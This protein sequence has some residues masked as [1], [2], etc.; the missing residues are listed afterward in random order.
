[1]GAPK[2]RPVCEFIE[3]YSG[4]SI[5]CILIPEI[6]IYILRGKVRLV[7]ESWQYFDLRLLPV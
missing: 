1:M 2:T 4:V 5:R 6:G 3:A 7:I